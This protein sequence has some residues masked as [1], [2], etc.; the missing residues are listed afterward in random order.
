MI[1]ASKRE[2]T[3]ARYGQDAQLYG[4]NSVRAESPRRSLFDQQSQYAGSVNALAQPRHASL[5]DTRHESITSGYFG[6]VGGTRSGSNLALQEMGR[7]TSTAF[8]GSPRALS[9][10]R[11][12]GLP[13]DEQIQMDVQASKSFRSFVSLGLLMSSYS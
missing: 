3:D 8:T 12:A 10:S 5:Y 2:D 7:P 4:S 13:S 6:G 9:P 11:R 1:A